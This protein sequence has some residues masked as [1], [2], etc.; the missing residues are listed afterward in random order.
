MKIELKTKTPQKKK[1]F[2]LIFFNINCDIFSFNS[3][4][5]CA[6]HKIVP[7]K[8]TTQDIGV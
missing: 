2:L 1:D 7:F 8:N 5:C 4:H 3:K 6:D